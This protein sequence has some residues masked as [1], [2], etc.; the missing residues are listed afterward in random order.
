MHCTD[1]SLQNLCAILEM[2]AAEVSAVSGAF[3]T[4]DA[5]GAAGVSSD[6]FIERRVF[7]GRYI[8]ESTIAIY[9]GRDAG[10]KSGALEAPAAPSASN[11]AHQTCNANCSPILAE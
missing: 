11:C 4:C 3:G 10:G 6:Y 5:C 9:D 2:Q 8:D 1:H 7:E